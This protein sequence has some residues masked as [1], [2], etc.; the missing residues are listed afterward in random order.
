MLKLDAVG[1]D[2][3]SPGKQ[4][5]RGLE[6]LSKV[7]LARWRASKSATSNT[8]TPECYA[9]GVS[10]RVYGG[11]I[12]IK[13]LKIGDITRPLFALSWINC[14]RYW[15]PSRVLVLCCTFVPLPLNTCR[16]PLIAV[17]RTSC[18][19]LIYCPSLA[20]LFCLKSRKGDARPEASPFLALCK[21]VPASIKLSLAAVWCFSFNHSA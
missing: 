20:S 16:E 6:F 7:P 21:S 18:S 15:A 11:I 10:Q 8:I 14:S 5:Y 9:V 17:L 4:I 1:T 19:R 2:L 3:V 13:I 12:E